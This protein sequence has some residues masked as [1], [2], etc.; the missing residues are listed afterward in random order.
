MIGVSAVAIAIA[1]WLLLRGARPDPLDEFHAVE[2]RSLQTF[3]DALGRQRANQIDEIALATVIDRDVLPAWR[4][5]RA[6]L[7]AAP[8]PERM[9]PVMQRYLAD[10]QTAWEAYSAALRAP[11]DA[12]AK[13]HYDAYHRKNSDATD[14]AREL[15]PLLH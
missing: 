8:L 10:R 5:M 14:D 11:S 7:D 15:G 13:P 2:R 9:R 1:G 12:A 6:H 4:A 3:N